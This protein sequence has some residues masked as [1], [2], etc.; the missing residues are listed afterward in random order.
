M[1]WLDG[2]L[3]PHALLYS[4][5]YKNTKLFIVLLFVC[6]KCFIAITIAF[7]IFVRTC[8]YYNS[9]PGNS[10]H[11]LG[12]KAAVCCSFPSG[13]VETTALFVNMNSFTLFL[14]TDYPIACSLS[15]IIIMYPLGQL[16]SL[17]APLI[18]RLFRW[19]YLPAAT[20]E[21]VII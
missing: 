19:V 9:L 3:N 20:L 21:H 11:S 4:S 2:I 5:L 17:C 15:N 12:L 10:N 6:F 8:F 14:D 1:S 7:L 13:S 16:Y 18:N